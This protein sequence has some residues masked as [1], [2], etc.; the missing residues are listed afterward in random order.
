[1]IPCSLCEASP[2]ITPTNAAPLD[3]ASQPTTTAQHVNPLLST[4]YNTSSTSTAPSST[5][6]G[7]NMSITELLAK[8]SASASGSGIMNSSSSSSAVS[9][10]AALKGRELPPH[11][12][13]QRDQP[14]TDALSTGF[15][16]SMSQEEIAAAKIK[17]LLGLGPAPPLTV[18]EASPIPKAALETISVGSTTPTIDGKTA[19]PRRKTKRDDVG[20]EYDSSSSPVQRHTSTRSMPNGQ[21]VGT[22]IRPSSTSTSRRPNVIDGLPPRNPLLKDSGYIPNSARNGPS[23]G[24]RKDELE[25]VIAGGLVD[26][27]SKGSTSNGGD[28]EED[29]EEGRKQFVRGILALIHVILCAVDPLVNQ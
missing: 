11:M 19:K 29:E 4:V 6:D 1:M 5:P 24:L 20:S 13:A 28:D 15:Q 23:T 14:I 22:P 26:A 7:G 16:T 2:P 25:R 18:A 27:R 9:A 10:A 17:H 3:A 8:L 12:E 21:E